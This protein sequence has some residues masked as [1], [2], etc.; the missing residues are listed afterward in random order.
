MIYNVTHVLIPMITPSLSECSPTAET[1][2]SKAFGSCK[3]SPHIYEIEHTYTDK[4][5]SISISVSAHTH[6]NTRLERE[7]YN[8]DLDS[9]VIRM[10]EDH[11]DDVK[12]LK[13]T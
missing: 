7:T 1:P 10:I 5:N 9:Y 8:I 4:P 13:P 11:R 12:T 3:E 2:Y 6:V